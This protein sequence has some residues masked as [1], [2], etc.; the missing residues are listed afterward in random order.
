[1]HNIK[2]RYGP[3]HSYLECHNIGGT[4]VIH[5]GFFFWAAISQWDLQKA[6]PLSG[7]RGQMF[8]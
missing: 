5:E 8:G 3:V 1:M 6:W 4:R 7:E 2:L